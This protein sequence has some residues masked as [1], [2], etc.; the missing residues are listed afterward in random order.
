MSYNIVNSKLTKSQINK[1]HSAIKNKT[2]VTLRLSI[3][4]FGEGEHYPHKLLLTNNQVKR[5][6]GTHGSSIDV[7]F[8]KT[9]LNKM[10]SGGFLANLLKF[11]IPLAKNVLLPLGLTAA[12]SATDAGIQKSI[13]GRGIDKNITLVITN[14]D[15]NK[16]LEL[17]KH[18]EDSDCLTKGSTSMIQ[19]EIKEQSGGFL[20]I[21]LGTL[22]A[23]LLGNILGGKGMYRAGKGIFRAGEGINKK[24]Y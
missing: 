4:N 21:L 14:N 8:S 2:D 13:L 15:A 7:K 23:S 1:L 16:I 11:A 19:N 24:F 20:P 9:Q 5:L 10:Q 6:Q 22:G 17:V 3:K 18:L 12:A